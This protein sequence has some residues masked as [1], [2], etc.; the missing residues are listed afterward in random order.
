MKLKNVNRNKLHQELVD[1]GIHPKYVSSLDD[2]DSHLGG[3]F[4]FD[5]DYDVEKVQSIIE[6][7]DPTPIE[8]DPT[9]EEILEQQLSE[10][11]ALVLSLYEMVLG[12]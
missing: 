10:T 1:A 11:N 7:H 3:E 8:L 9:R 12:G 6:K 5:K 2:T 4:I